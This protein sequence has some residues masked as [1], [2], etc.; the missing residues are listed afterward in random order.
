MANAPSPLVT[1]KTFG[2]HLLS[3]LVPATTLAFVATGPHGGYGALVWLAVVPLAVAIDRRSPADRRPP[4]ESMPAWPF[5]LL[6]GAL[7][8]LQ[9]ANVGLA[10]ALVTQS[11]LFSVDALVSVL[12]VGV[13]SAYSAIVVAHELIHRRSALAFAA[14]RL[15]LVST[16]YDHFATEHVR[17]HHLRVGT[18]E[19]PATARFGE[20]FGAFFKRTV[21]GQLKSAFAIEEKRLGLAGLPLW[22]PR[23]LGN[24]VLQGLLVEAALLVGLGLGLGLAAAVVFAGQAFVAITLLEVVNYFEHWGLRRSGRKVRPMDSWDAE[25]WFTLHA[26][27]GLS[28]HADHHAYAARPYQDL[29]TWEESP[30]L[31]QG[32]VGMVFLVLLEN[33]RAKALLTE[34]LRRKRLGPFAEV[35]AVSQAA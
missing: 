25:S 13:S 3:L 10:L 31:P 11:G 29:R 18:D 33:D 27:V 26:L 9:L 17:G 7:V 6:L 30:K 15:L 4:V 16:L 12:L 28:R 21:P 1:A 5:D 32:Y 20:S 34:E 23:R 14:G 35:E 22:H 2:T 19:D 24:R 8:L